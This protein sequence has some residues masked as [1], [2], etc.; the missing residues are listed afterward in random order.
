MKPSKKQP[1]TKNTKLSRHQVWFKKKVVQ[2]C[3]SGLMDAHQTWNKYHISKKGY[4]YTNGR[5]CP[6]LFV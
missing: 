4:T 5:N 2:L 3:L 6:C 1:I